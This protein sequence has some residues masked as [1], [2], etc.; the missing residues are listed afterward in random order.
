MT[1]SKFKSKMIKLGQSGAYAIVG[2]FFAT[3]L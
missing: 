3:M 1:I 2:S